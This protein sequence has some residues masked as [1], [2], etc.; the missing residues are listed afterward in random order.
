[1]K[2]KMRLV[3]VRNL[4]NSLFVL[5]QLILISG[6]HRIASPDKCQKSSTDGIRKVNSACV[7]QSQA[8]LPI[9]EWTINTIQSLK[10]FSGLLHW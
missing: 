1:M 3:L 9:P 8:T 4:I 7:D 5:R 2:I 6:T 10:M